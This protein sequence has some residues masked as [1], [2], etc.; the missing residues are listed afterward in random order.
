MAAGTS[1]ARRAEP[2]GGPQSLTVGGVR[3]NYRLQ[4]QGEPLICIHGV[5]SYLEASRVWRSA[6]PIASAS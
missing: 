6:S 1:A 2:T 4:G 5:G 3:L